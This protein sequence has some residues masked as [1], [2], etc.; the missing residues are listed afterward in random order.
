MAEISDE[1]VDEFVEL[2][3]ERGIKFESENDAQYNVRM[4]L[5]F[6]SDLIDEALAYQEKK[7]AKKSRPDLNT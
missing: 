2:A 6:F 3:K 7:W 5:L 1:I 4:L